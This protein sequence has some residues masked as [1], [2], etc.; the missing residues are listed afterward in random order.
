MAGSVSPMTA[1]AALVAY[2]YARRSLATDKQVQI[3]DQVDHGRVVVEASG[4]QLGDVVSEEVSASRYARKEREAWPLLLEAIGAGK[5]GVLILWESSRGDRKLSEWAKLLDLCV[6]TGTLIHVISHERT[7]D[8]RNHRDWKTLAS[9]GVEADHFSQRLSAD[10]RRGK[11]GAMRRGRPQ[12]PPPHG[13]AVRYDPRTG[14]TAG[15]DVTGDAEAVRR[16]VLGA[17]AHVPNIRIAQDLDEAGFLSPTGGQWNSTAV[18]TI[19]LNPSYAGLIS[20]GDAL[21]ERDEAFPA[22]VSRE[23]HQAAAAAILPRA[24]GERPQSV[25]HLMGG[26]A[27]CDGGGCMRPHPYK[28]AYRCQEGGHNYVPEGWLDE[29]VG[30]LV[31]AKLARPDARDL[32]ADDTNERATQLRGELT[33]LLARRRKFRARAAAGDLD[34]DALVDIEADLTPQ[35]KRVER[36]LGEV[37]YVPALR[38][39]LEADDVFETWASYT[40]Q[41]RREIIVALTGITVMRVPRSAPPAERYDKARVVPDWRPQPLRPVGRRRGK[42]IVRG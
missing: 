39:I 4:W 9:E 17:A 2:I 23:E 7:Y 24:Y 1:L 16:I 6:D 15:W 38:G 36:E 34:D 12:G 27:A 8:L 26:L 30:Y 40:V 41:A 19:A 35:V 18:R 3:E 10:T 14:K 37:R 31:C 5:V 32:Y 25:V 11:R 13:Y 29:A 33:T 22:I 28:D 21:I 42:R 20:L